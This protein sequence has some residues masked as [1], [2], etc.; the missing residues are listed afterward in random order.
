MHLSIKSLRVHNAF[1]REFDI[2]IHD[3]SLFQI[4]C[5]QLVNKD[6]LDYESHDQN[7][8]HQNSQWEANWVG[9]GETEVT[10]GWF[11]LV[12]NLARVFW[13]NHKA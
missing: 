12:E 11:V 4:N 6:L 9:R 1:P 8:S 3:I 7:Q 10:N 13:I 2:F 5:L